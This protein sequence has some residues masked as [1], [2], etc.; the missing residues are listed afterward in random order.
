MIVS[1]IKRKFISFGTGATDVNAQVIPATNTATAYT[2]TP[3]A[4]ESSAEVSAHLNGINIALS[5]ITTTTGDI[6]L[7][8]YSGLINNTANQNVTGFNFVNATVRS[9]RAQVSLTITAT[10]NLY[11]IYDVLAVQ[12]AADWVVSF[13]G[14][15]DSIPGINIHSTAAGQ[16]QVDLGSITGFS[17]SKLAFR[18]TV[19]Q[20]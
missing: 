2:P 11:A 14:A 16:V 18:A 15:G 3:V 1:N 13:T 8:T 10:T 17:A 9:F 4:S 20:V 12:R 6:N 5:G 19:T 7:T